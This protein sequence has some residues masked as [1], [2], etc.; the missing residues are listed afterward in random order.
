MITKGMGALCVDEQVVEWD[1]ASGKLVLHTTA[2]GAPLSCCCKGY[3][4]DLWITPNDSDPSYTTFRVSAAHDYHPACFWV[5]Q[6]CYPLTAVP[7]LVLFSKCLQWQ[8]SGAY[9]CASSCFVKATYYAQFANCMCCSVEYPQPYQTKRNPVGYEP[10]SGDK[11]AGVS[12][13][14]LLDSAV[15]RFEL[16]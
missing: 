10:W 13:V 7:A 12:G 14:P 9:P 4:A 16:V 8:A 3:T 5:P 1:R 11:P 6:L 15:E 2:V